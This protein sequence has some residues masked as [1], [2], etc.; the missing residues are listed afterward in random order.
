MKSSIFLFILT[1]LILFIIYFFVFYLYRLKKKTILKSLEVEFLKVRFGFKDKD[2]NPK[3][4]GFIICLI[5]P[6]IISLTGTIVTLPNW[7][8]I[9]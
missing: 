3:K 2:F 7:N 6:L 9:I 8:Y 4:I 1:Y 5:D